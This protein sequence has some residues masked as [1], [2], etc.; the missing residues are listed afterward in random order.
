MKTH[1]LLKLPSRELN[2]AFDEIVPQFNNQCSACEQGMGLRF[3]PLA[4]M[5]LKK[6]LT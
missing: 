6:M 4:N 1:F 3:P 5:P 2:R